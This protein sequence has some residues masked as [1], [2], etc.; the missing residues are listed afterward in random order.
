VTAW[1]TSNRDAVL[2]A[3]EAD[4]AMDRWL[5]THSG[6]LSASPR[7]RGDRPRGGEDGW[8]RLTMIG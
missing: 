4:G 1:L 8:G 5:E 2:V 7:V 3:L 6:E